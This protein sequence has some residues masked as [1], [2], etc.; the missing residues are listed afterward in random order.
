MSANKAFNQWNKKRSALTIDHEE[1]CYYSMYGKN[2]NVPID[3]CNC[4]CYDKAIFK[5]GYF[6]AKGINNYE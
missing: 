2:S 6:A 3:E 4:D 5:A 1:N